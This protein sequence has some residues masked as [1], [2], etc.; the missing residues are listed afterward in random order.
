MYC[1]HNAMLDAGSWCGQSVYFTIA[2][3]RRTHSDFI[4]P[5]IF[6]RTCG[7]YAR[8]LNEWATTATTNEH[9]VRFQ[10]REKWRKFTLPKWINRM[11]SKILKN[12]SF[13]N[14]ILSVL[15]N[16]HHMHQCSIVQPWKFDTSIHEPILKKN[17]AQQYFIVFVV[18]CWMLNINIDFWWLLLLLYETNLRNT[19]SIQIIDRK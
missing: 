14:A 9:I 7:L 15:W 16:T 13:E 10:T 1:I 11:A 5:A 8:N 12:S 2:C 4:L 17:Y 6:A 19:N 3:L 18:E